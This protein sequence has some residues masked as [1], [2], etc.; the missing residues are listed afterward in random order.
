MHRRVLLT[1]VVALLAALA[2]VAAAPGVAQAQAQLKLNHQWPATTPGSAVDQWFADEVAKR[3]ANEVQVKIFWSEAL[4]KAKENLQLVKSGA[5][6]MAAMSPA[7]FPSDLPFFTA[8]NSL[9]MA[10]DNIRQAGIIMR[11]LMEKVPAYA[12]EAKTNNLKPLFFHHL[13][14]YL[15]VCKEPVR[16]LADLKGKK[17]RT[18]GEDMPRLMQAAG[19]TGVTI[20]LP[21]IYENLQRGVVNCAPFSVD[22]IQTYKIYEVA[23]YVTEVVAWEGPSWGVWINL[24][25]WNKLPDKHKQT[26][27]AVA[28]EAN[29]RDLQAVGEAADKARAFLAQNGVQFIP[30]AESERLKWV[31]ANPDFFADW[32]NKMEKLGKGAAARQTVAIW[33]ELREKHR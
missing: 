6:D 27:L 32:I 20:F 17:I 31:Q 23:K 25:R 26:M 19:G 24:D 3:T 10:M 28:D 9:P 1:T 21:E 14:P 30:F 15:L 7:Y 11:T 13:N 5:I 22:L 16:A 29:K 2:L 12:E 18:W 4:G 33:K 8:P